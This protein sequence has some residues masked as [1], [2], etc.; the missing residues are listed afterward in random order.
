MN[1]L[2]KTDIRILQALQQNG[3]L[4]NVELAEFAALSPS[5][6][7]RRL[8]QLEE[9]G[10]IRRYAA[11][12]S[13]EA[14]GLGLQ[15]VIRVTVKK[16][17]AAREKFTEAVQSWKEVLNCLAL[18]GESDYMLQA[19]FVDMADFSHFILEVLLALP[20]VSDAKSSFVL[21]EIKHTTA[22]PLKHLPQFPEHSS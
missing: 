12:L 8:K 3:R 14:V 2:D 22:L 16:D 6:C 15:A 20:F 1:E 5:P 19:Y 10:V 11:L 7:L 21:K 9:S 17:Q 4:T 18:T 13:P